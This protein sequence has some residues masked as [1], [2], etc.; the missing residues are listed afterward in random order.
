MRRAALEF[1]DGMYANLGIGMPTLAANYIP[2]GMIINMQ[3]ENGIIGTGPFP[4]RDQV[5][6]SFVYVWLSFYEPTL[7]S[8][9]SLCAAFTCGV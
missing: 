7:V 3:S 2:K 1:K 9:S 8:V 4:T 5:K 6:R